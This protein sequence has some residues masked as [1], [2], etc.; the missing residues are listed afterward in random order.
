VEKSTTTTEKTLFPIKSNELAMEIAVGPR[1][2]G[3]AD[4]SKCAGC[5]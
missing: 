4:P 5:A 1:G 2:R 3:D